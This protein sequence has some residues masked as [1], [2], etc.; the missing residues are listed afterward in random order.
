MI[1]IE[2]T[3][4]RDIMGIHDVGD[5]VELEFSAAELTPGREVSRTVQKAIGGQRE[6]LHHYGLRKWSVVTGPLARATLEAVLEFLASVEGG[7]E[8]TFEAWRYESGPSLD[9]DFTTGSLR[10]AEGVTCT[11]D[12]E[13]YDLMRLVGEG[14]GGADDWYQVSFAVKELP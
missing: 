6:T 14:T 7:E 9:L 1:R 4:A 12:S 11:L 13:G 3:A 2:F 5:T 8:F 10:V